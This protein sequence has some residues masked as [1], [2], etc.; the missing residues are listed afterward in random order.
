MAASSSACGSSPDVAVEPTLAG[1]R[2]G[3]HEVLERALEHLGV[4]GAP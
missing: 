4:E 1:L 3:C 2:A